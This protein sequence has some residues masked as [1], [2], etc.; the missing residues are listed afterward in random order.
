MNEFSLSIPYERNYPNIFIFSDILKEYNLLTPR[1]KMV[2]VTLN[3]DDWGLMTL[4][5]QFHD[6]FY[7]INK[8]KEAPIF[9]M[10]NE[11][12]FTIRTILGSP[13]G[14]YANTKNKNIEDIIRWQ[15]K[16]ETKI[17]NEEDIL[18]KTSIP[19]KNTNETLL[20]IFKTIQQVIAKEDEKFLKKINK[21]IDIKSF[22]R[23]S[24]L[25]A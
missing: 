12:D 19:N 15:G 4:E 2:K 1:H 11:N 17:F 22:A 13:D 10:T 3:G 24:A 20:S 7:A 14:I 16:L 9:K 23:V 8:L 21:Y 18:N 6:S 25:T 5:E